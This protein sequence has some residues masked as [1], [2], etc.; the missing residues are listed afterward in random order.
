MSAI[1]KFNKYDEPF[2]HP[3]YL[4]PNREWIEIGR[5]ACEQCRYHKPRKCPAITQYEQAMKESKTTPKPIKIIT[6]W[7]SRERK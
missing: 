2:T 1:L 6:L 7:A 5:C 3:G 4:P